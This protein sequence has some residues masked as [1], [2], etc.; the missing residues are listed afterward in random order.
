[1]ALEIDSDKVKDIF[2]IIDKAQEIYKWITNRTAKPH[3]EDC[4]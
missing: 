1:M 4:E 3:R 2:K